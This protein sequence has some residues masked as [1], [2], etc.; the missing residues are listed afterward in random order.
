MLH[1]AARVVAT[2]PQYQGN[3]ASNTLYDKAFD[4]GLLLLGEGG[5]LGRGAQYHQ[6]VGTVLY[7][8]F[9]QSGKGLEVDALV[10]LERRDKCHT[11]SA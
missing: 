9:N 2:Q 5:S 7:Q 6:V 11:H 10:F 1:D 3:A 4:L 8:I